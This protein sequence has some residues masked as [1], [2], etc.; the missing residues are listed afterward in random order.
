MELRWF[1]QS[2]YLLT[3][4]DA[5]IAIDPFGDLAAEAGR[6]MRFYP[7]VECAAELLLV[8]HEHVDHNAVGQVSGVSQ[9]IR[10]TAGRIAGPYGEIVAV[11]SEHDRVAGTE[12]GPNTIYVF[13]FAGLRFAHFGDFGQAS[14]RDEQRAAIGQIDVLIVPAGG[15]PT[16]GGADAA[17]IVEALAPTVVVPMHYRTEAIDFLEPPDEFLAA[18]G[19]EVERAETS[20]VEL[21]EPLAR[22][23]LLLAP[24]V[25]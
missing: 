19:W 11:A 10:S 6:D 24:P 9:T 14:L 8:T 17:A 1:G 2:A 13:P 3:D 4:G 12:R 21:S 22:R 18:L 7:P 25:K 5:A 16:T 23:V 15:G 20:V